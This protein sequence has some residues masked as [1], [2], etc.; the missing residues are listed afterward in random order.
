MNKIFGWTILLCTLVLWSCKPIG[1]T[2]QVV[3]KAEEGVMEWINYPGKKEMRKKQKIVLISGDE[4]Y[5][6]EEALPMLAKILST[7][8]GFDCTVLFAQDPNFPGIID[9]NETKNIPGL[10]QLDDA[11]LMFLFTRFRE[12]PGEQ[13]MHFQRY[14]EKGKPII[15][16][17]TATHAFRFVDTTSTWRH[18]GNYYNGEKKDWSGGF[19]K[20]ILG[21]NWHSHHGHHKHQST[22]GIYAPN[23]NVHPVLS[24]I[25]DGAIWGPTDV[26]GVP[27]PL[28]DKID[29]ILLGQVVDR[30]N[31]FDEADALFGMRTSDNRVATKNEANNHVKNPND[32][33]MPIVWAKSYQV[34][35]GREGKAITSTIGSSTD[36]LNEALRQLFVN[37]AY[38]L[39]DLPVPE[40]A[41]VSI[42]GAYNP[43]QFQ[44]HTDT[45][46]DDKA[47]RI[48]GDDW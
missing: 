44:F 31:E 17:R 29:P 5:R 45:Y 39:L 40:K 41:E 6:S 28:F 37:A 36:L 33:M 12:L 10:E 15:G 43:T 35:N 46:W 24:G 16:I 23:A 19:G 20:K 11:D 18:W 30:E 47:I 25:E 22:R 7:H 42:V 48:S 8:H 27:L 13:M 34:E 14:L 3:E 2:E 32:P 21:V 26:Y 9:P 4:E 1:N 38:H